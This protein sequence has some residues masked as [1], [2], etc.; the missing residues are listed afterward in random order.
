MRPPV[1]DRIERRQ[2]TAGDAPCK[3]HLGG[4]PRG[5]KDR[6]TLRLWEYATWRVRMRAWCNQIKAKLLSEEHDPEQPQ[7]Y[8]VIQ[9]TGCPVDSPSTWLSWWEGKTVPRPT[10]IAAAE[11]L[12][13]ASSRLLE[14]TDMQTALCRHFISLD[15]INTRFRRA[16]RPSDYRREQANRL[17]IGLNEAWISFLDTAPPRLTNPFSVVS[18]LGEPP[19]A[20]LGGCELLPQRA[21]W[22]Q[23][24]GGNV[25]RWALPSEAVSE[26]SWLE[27]LSIFR[28]LSMLAVSDSLRHPKL[29]EMWALDLASATLVVRTLIEI[30]D[31]RRPR[32]AS[33]RMGHSGGMHHISTAAFFGPR[34][35]LDT[36][37]ARNVASNVYGDQGEVALA[38]LHAARDTYYNAFAGLGIPEA[39]LRALNATH[40]DKT[41][42]GAFSAPRARI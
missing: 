28:F 4:R 36:T 25:A 38:N 2:R 23:K 13:P 14:L 7:T 20:L 41:W 31:L 6:P 18:Q 12:A 15:I 22:A 35:M 10:H 34:S 21:V 40:W 1:L 9:R 27:P 42:D 19:E 5:P 33:I 39:A 37:A 24:F 32:F 8:R 29:M 11:R 26:H 3:S 16:G 30:A 17:L